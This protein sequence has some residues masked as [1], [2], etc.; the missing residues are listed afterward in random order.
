[1]CVP[2]IPPPA[3]QLR[4]EKQHLES[5]LERAERE[6]ATYVTEVREVSLVLKNDL[7]FLLITDTVKITT[8]HGVT[9]F[10]T[11]VLAKPV[12]TFFFNHYLALHQLITYNN[13][14]FVLVVLSW[15]Q[16]LRSPSKH[17]N[18]TLNFSSKICWLN[19]RPDLMAHIQRLSDRMR[20]WI[21]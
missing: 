18:L 17:N 13:I 3:L 19:C 10:Q 2:L 14:G 9:L 7:C 4:R 20:S 21:W 1:M 6:S 12:S 16:H 11:V 8:Q 5:E 15:T